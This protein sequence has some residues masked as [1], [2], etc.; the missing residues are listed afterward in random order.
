MKKIKIFADGASIE[1]IKVTNKNKLVSGFTT[2]PSL[3]LSAG[4]RS[5]YDFAK[6]VSLII[7]DKPIS[8][9]VL[10]DN[11][12][13]IFEQS[14]KLY[15]LSKN[16]FVKIPIVGSDG[17]SN[18][19]VIKKALDLGIKINI[20]AVFTIEQL[21]EIKN[22]IKI[23]D[24]LI[25]SIFAGRIADTGVDPIPLMKEA[26]SLY[27]DFLNVEILWASPR[28]VLN[29]YQASEIGCH[30]ITMPAD[31]ISKL[32]LYQKDHLQYSI[33]TSK[34]FFDDARKAKYTL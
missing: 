3:M 2:N 17:S 33:E 20:T 10:E 6:D 8:F 31:L 25:I 7:G 4:V 13:K 26:I 34:M 14:Q 5:Y 1:D 28:E 18:I 12:N 23:T 11:H 19:P 16:V 21:L 24:E 30:I 27:K 9:E 29:Y 32:S 22:N 15:K